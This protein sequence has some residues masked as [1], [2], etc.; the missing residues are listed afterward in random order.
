MRPMS[1]SR[2]S[3][4]RG[5]A[6]RLRPL[7]GD[8]RGGVLVEFAVLSPVLIILLLGILQFG[9]LFSVHSTMLNAARETAR[10]M[11]VEGFSE[12]QGAAFANQRL[13]PWGNLPFQV[14]ARRPTPPDRDVTVEI[15]VPMEA[16]AIID[17]L[18]IFDGREMTVE[19][20]MRTE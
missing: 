8:E 13:G 12:N 4:V 19:M 5:I 14:E 2:H 20:V 10:A 1:N 9:M 17:I 16:A 18:G 6:R 15:S 3:T 7:R 11:A